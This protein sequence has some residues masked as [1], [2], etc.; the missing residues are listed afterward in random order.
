MRASLI[1]VAS[2]GLLAACTHT[3]EPER[4]YKELPVAV[5]VGCVKDRPARP[6]SLAERIPDAE[7]DALAPG[8]MARAVQA[9]AGDRLNYEDRLEA[10]TA[11]CR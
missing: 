6:Q 1:G 5:A 4:V 9:Q 7:W 11:G 10:A 8:A 2:L 3:S